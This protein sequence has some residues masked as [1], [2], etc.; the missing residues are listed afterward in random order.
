MGNRILYFSRRALPSLL[1]C[2]GLFINMR[3]IAGA[4]EVKA[5]ISLCKRT[6]MAKG[7]EDLYTDGAL[8]RSEAEDAEE[9]SD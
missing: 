7:W 9:R 6:L 4:S 1:E 8:R 5:G 2:R 3:R